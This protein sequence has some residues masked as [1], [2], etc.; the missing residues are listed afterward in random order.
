VSEPRSRAARA[1][2]SLLALFA[3]VHGTLAWGQ[4][5]QPTLV[6]GRNV[7]MVS[8]TKW[9]AGDPYL[10]R[11]NEPSVAA[12]TRNPLHLLAG[13][14]DYRTVDIP[15][16]DGAAET[17]DAWLGLFKSF[18]GGQRWQ[19]NLLPGYPQ[20]LS[21]NGLASPLKGYQAGADPVVRAGTNG[22]LYYAGLVFDRPAPS[23]AGAP[24]PAQKSAIFVARFIDNNNIENADSIAYL[25]STLVTS[26]PGTTGGFLDKPWM[27][28]DVPRDSGPSCRIVTPGEGAPATQKLPAGNVY[29]AY[30]LAI[31][32]PTGFRSEIYLSRSTNC[33]AT[34]T[35][36]TRLSRP[37]DRI[38]QGASIAIDP[39]TGQVYVAWRRIATAPTDA[40]DAILVVK[41]TTLGKKFSPPGEAT[42]FPRGR[43]LGLDPARFF[44]HGRATAPTAAG[45]GEGEFDQGTTPESFRTNAYPS[46]V[47]DGDGRLYLA[48]A[49]RGYGQVRPGQEGDARI[50]LS[51]SRDGTA[52][53]PPRAV[54]E[55][56]LPG[57]QIMPTLAF[58]GGRLMLAFYDLRDDVS[59]VF[60]PY[61]DDLTSVAASGFRHTLDLRAATAAPGDT[62]VFE[63]S[64]RVSDYLIGTDPADP[65][66]RPYQLQFNPPN[67]PMFVRG[68][69]PFVGDYVDLAAAPAFVLRQNGQWAFNTGGAPPVFHAVW[70]DNRDVRPPDD[71]DWSHY[72]PPTTRTSSLITGEEMLPCDPGASGSRNQNIYTARLTRGLLAGSPGN[73][74][75]LST[76]MA[77]G[78]V[79]FAQNS[80][81]ATKFF[82]IRVE[83]QP[84]GGYASFDQFD[85]A[86]TQVD[87]TTPASST[88]SRTIY[89]TSSDPAAS[90]SISVMEIAAVGGAA[91]TGGLTDTV[92]LNPDPSN[93]AVMNPAVMNPAVM[94]PDIMNA[95]VYN[96]AVMNPAVMNPAVMNPAVM[97]PA[98]MNPDLTNPA[99]MNPDLTNPDLTSLTITNTT[100]VNP[101]VMNPAVMNPAVMNP[102]VM[103]PDL[104]NPAVM[105]PDLVNG[106]ISDVSWTVTNNGNTTAV[107]HVNLF[108][109]ASTTKVCGAGESGSCI[110][111]QLVVRK[112]YSTP[113]TS[114]CVLEV[115]TQN[116]LIANVPNPRFVT[117]SDAGTS[118]GVAAHT[119]LAQVGKVKRGGS[120]AKAAGLALPAQNDP[121]AENATVWLAPGESV[122][123]TLRLFDPD[124]SDNVLVDGVS[125]D[126]VF[127]PA[128]LGGELTPVIVADAVDTPAVQAGVTE[129]AVA[130]P[131]ASTLLFLVQP[132]SAVVGTAIAPS[133]V[134]QVRDQFFTPVAGVGV[135]LALGTNPGGAVLGG[136]TTATTD[137]TGAAT[138]SGVTISATGAGYQLRAASGALVPALSAPF[139]VVNAN[140][141]PPRLRQLV[142]DRTPFALPTTMGEPASDG[143]NAA[144][145]YV[146]TT[147]STALFLR[148]AGTATPVRL[149]QMGDPVP[150]VPGSVAD[151][152]QSVR[153]NAVGDIF[154]AVEYFWPGG[155][156]KRALL[157]YENGVFR[158]VA[159]SGDVAPGSGGVV[160][161]RNLVVIGLNDAGDAAFSASLAPVLT[162]ART[163]LFITPRGGAPVR[164]VGYGEMAPGTG[165]GTF[166]QITGVSFNSRGEIL[167][168]A[169]IVGGVGGGGVFIGS[170][171][172][173]RK[174]V[175]NGDPDPNGG[176]F[177]LATL[178]AVPTGTLNNAGQVAF[179]QGARLYLTEPGTT[180]GVSG[181]TVVRVG[182]ATTLPWPAT[183]ISAVNGFALSDSGAIALLATLSGAPTY[184]ILQL[185]VGS[186]SLA[187]VAARGQSVPGGGGV[188]FNNPYAPS[189]NNTG[190]ICFYS[191]TTNTAVTGIF[192]D[193]A[194]ALAAVMLAGQTSPLGG[195]YNTQQSYYH[196]LPNGDVYFE[197]ALT[198][199]SADYGAFLATGSGTTALMSTADPLPAGSKVTMRNLWV[200]AAGSYVGFS[201]QRAGGSA[202]FFVHDLGN[203]TTVKV[204]ATGD[205]VGAER[206][207]YIN[208]NRINVSQNGAAVILANTAPSRQALFVWTPGGGAQ[209]LLVPGDSI[210]GFGTVTSV[211]TVVPAYSQ[212]NDEGTAVFVA[213][214]TGGS[215]VFVAGNNQLTPL[216][217]VATGD[218]APTGGTFTTVNSG[219]R[220]INHSR[221]VAFLGTTS[222][223]AT[224]IFVATPGG[225]VAKIMAIGDTFIPGVT[226]SSIYTNLG[227]LGLND[228]G[229]VVFTAS[230]SDGRVGMFVATTAAV[231]AVALNGAASPAGGTYNFATNSVDIRINNAGDILFLA[232]LAGGSSSSAWLLRRASAP[233]TIET[234]EAQ[235]QPAP[236]T[237]GVFAAWPGT[238]NSIPGENAALAE[239]GDVAIFV[240]VLIN[241]TSRFGLFRYTGPGTLQVVAFRGDRMPDCPGDPVGAISQGIG[242]GDLGRFAVRVTTV[243]TTAVD[244]IY[245]TAAPGDTVP[246]GCLVA[247]RSFVPVTALAASPPSGTGQAASSQP[248]AISAPN[249]SWR[250]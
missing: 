55:E 40:P 151:L 63:P 130:L 207:T 241:G 35:A 51:T 128:S 172:G 41:S 238:L 112:T 11:Q 21:P 137:A 156:T 161:E 204:V 197:A 22:L 94:N 184:A 103:N 66:Q 56:A 192:C 107:F 108:L 178:A 157:M 163:A 154:V 205:V 135:T 13:A 136:P 113:T 131:E 100:V 198:G 177:A 30:T 221:L 73:T 27:A 67:L 214:R 134:V 34:W 19:T 18:D 79:V 65:G 88:A 48:W 183:T 138:F 147:T 226:F 122:V 236:G 182:P 185:S 148:R 60:A 187:A 37:E 229:Q 140:P 240:P 168:R 222:L 95:E 142:N 247:S 16:V 233:G 49:E 80:T 164:I 246:P 150:G 195:T 14:N 144:G 5:P 191:T 231:Q 171:G 173:V 106:T 75:P 218:A 33:G 72:T 215:G 209:T 243:G 58:G 8:G 167:F 32:D 162:P 223:G 31:S 206:I 239:T 249:A 213:N 169:A 203:S 133:I 180:P 29:V 127:L 15:F 110:A 115:Q 85:T 116:I 194:G 174:V 119:M 104:A 121:S 202:G 235:G 141:T 193:N 123:M 62:P 250:R 101:A 23:V 82:R 160:F 76:T 190:R 89:V 38:N 97:N 234:V 124:T 200:S 2:T 242:A 146:F 59:R 224:G 176:T 166:D 71:G 244:G 12:S 47:I 9:P 245:V 36:P 129:P 114:G 248:C 143:M 225:A 20:D 4:T 61:I 188:N 70:T 149:L 217:V 111:T 228:S 196:L 92:M 109:A 175:A 28:V 120:T 7:N 83:N 98:V 118:S 230:L 91:I 50:L 220:W 201:A 77:R 1:A 46:I 53:T 132:A 139:N 10:Q 57:H 78:F 145:D 105:N 216:K 26:N 189:M 186:N 86:V 237:A 43:K 153:I 39:R 208:T 81:P 165:G 90:V 25:G 117:P 74:K 211:S 6:V 170:R 227:P 45:G 155:T 54:V 159:D 3:V 232:P 44:E 64:A 199:T 24:P 181:P 179:V 102:A 96:P 17:G 87:V 125:I 84:V 219:A 69:S 52:W 210:D 158:T 126:P 93:P 152:V 68:T 42:R 99:V 212:I